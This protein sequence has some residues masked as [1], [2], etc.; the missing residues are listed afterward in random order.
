M[1]NHSWLTGLILLS[2]FVAT[3]YGTVMFSSLNRALIVTA[4]PQAGQVM[5]A[6]EDTITV[7]W[8]YNTSFPAGTDSNYTTVKIML[9]YAPISQMD[10]GWRRTEDQLNKDK[11]CQHEIV[12][13]PYTRS[14]NNFTYTVQKDVPSATYF[15]RAYA[16]DSHGA[17]VAYGQTTNAQKT[18][19]LF[20][21]QAI[22]G[23]HVSLDVASA[24]FSA[25]SVISLLGFFF[26]E[27]RKAKSQSK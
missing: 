20:D 3:C 6:G 18:T 21:V 15:I 7:S 22:S 12:S 14:N 23:R 9:C 1:A 4:T 27:K 16:L 11:T 10:R 13:R 2:C 24:C 5:Q 17:E 19:N 25:F 8:S 26:M